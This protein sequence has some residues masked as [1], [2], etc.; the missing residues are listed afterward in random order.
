MTTAVSTNLAVPLARPLPSSRAVANRAVAGHDGER[1]PALRAG[2]RPG[3][4]GA[5]A[6]V[7]APVRLTRRGRVVVFAALV[8]LAVA[9]VS[10]VA[11]ASS[12]APAG[13]SRPPATMVVGAGDTLWT[14]ATQVD[15][16]ADPRETIA[17]LR[18]LNGLTGSTIEAGQELVLPN[19]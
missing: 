4:A 7:Q 19:R 12:A 17:E 16:Q 10:T 9:A 14:V 2:A 11:V 6:V 1:R 8:L 5:R 13:Q 15:P 18:R 3:V